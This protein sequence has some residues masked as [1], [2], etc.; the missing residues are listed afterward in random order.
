[1]TENAAADA[2]TDGALTVCSSGAAV[3]LFASLGGTPQAG[4]AWI[5]PSAVVGGQYD[6]ATM[7]PGVYIY[8]VTGT[9]PCTNATAAVTVTETGEPNAGT[10][11]TLTVCST[12][13]AASLFAQLG[14]TPDAGGTWTGPSPVVGGQYDPATMTPGVYIY[15]LA[16]VAPCTGANSTVTVTETAPPNA[17]LAGTL[18]VCAGGDQ[19]DLFTQLGGTPEAGGSWTSPG[20]ASS[21]GLFDPTVDG[22]G[23]YVYTIQGGACA[24]S[25]ATVTVTLLSGPNAGN[26]GTVAFCSTDAP[27]GLTSLLSGSPDATGVWTN[28]A[29]NTVPLNFDPAN[30]APG[31]FTYTVTG[32]TQCPTD[33]AILTITVNQAPQAGTSGSLQLCSTDATVALSTG[34]GGTVDAGGAWT[35]PDG[36]AHGSSLDPAVDASGIYTYTIVGVAPCPSATATVTV[37]LVT[38]PDAG[39]GGPVVLCSSDATVNLLTLLTGTPQSGG[40]WTGPD[41][42]LAGGLFQPSTGS[43]GQYVY[44]I[45]PDPVCGSAQATLDIVVSQAANAGTSAAVTLCANAP[46]VDLLTLLGGTPDSNGSWSG[47]DGALPSGILDPSQDSSGTYVYTV[48]AQAPC[49][50]ATA[51]VEV[52]IIAS[53]LAA[54]E[55]ISNGACVPAEVILSSAYTGPGSC[56]WLLGNGQVIQDCGPIT[57]VYDD[58]GTYDVTLIIDAGNGCGADTITL[59]GLVN[60]YEQPIASFEFLPSVLST[61]NTA[62]FFNNTSSGAVSYEWDFD[63]LGTS[64]EEDTR[65][66][67]PSVLGDEYTVCLTAI[68]SELCVDSVCRVITINDGPTVHVPNAF[69]PDDDGINDTFRPIMLG[70]DQEFYTFEI[71]DRYGQILFTTT[72]IEASWNG[73]LADGTEV[74]IGVFVWRVTARDAYSGDRFERIGHVTLLR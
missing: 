63:G 32:N 13:A 54:V 11:S 35:G 72:D 7:T 49:Q 50:P 29:G 74:A 38:A 26:D 55:V 45:G 5:G 53:P 40:T 30:S 20:G 12:G 36:Q 52:V 73:Q 34:L 67:F 15:T 37:T 58:P 48:S 60:V 71:F 16:A 9:A 66:I 23:A 28:A 18:E 27:V 14:G 8:T 47:P 41:G 6:P 17:G 44:T 51:N 33:E 69:S 25:S 21:T 46:L 19:V 42:P 4:G 2:G 43:A 59:P 1:V 70:F 56:T 68:A 57:A 64:S 10:N 3:S 62:V 61:P 39:V 65:F 22:A 24:N 31:V